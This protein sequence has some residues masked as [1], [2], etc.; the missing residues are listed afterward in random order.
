MDGRHRGDTPADDMEVCTS[1]IRGGRS[2][3]LGIRPVV[4]GSSVRY[5]G[6]HP[7]DDLPLGKV[8]RG[9]GVGGVVSGCMQ[10]LK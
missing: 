1:V 9:H 2:T 10:H 6:K 8:S 7:C 3:C 5:R 4:I